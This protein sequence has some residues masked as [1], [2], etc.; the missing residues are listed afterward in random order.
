VICARL[1]GDTGQ[2]LASISDDFVLALRADA[3]GVGAPPPRRAGG[4]LAISAALPLTTAAANLGELELLYPEPA[5]TV[6][7][8]SSKGSE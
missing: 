6:L 2:P 3:P 5:E 8:G 1:T 7:T 4:D